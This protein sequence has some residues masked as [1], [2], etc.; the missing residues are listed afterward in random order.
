MNYLLLGHKRFTRDLDTRGCLWRT[1][2][3]GRDIRPKNTSCYNTPI[4]LGFP[5][6]F[7]PLLAPSVRYRS[8]ISETNLFEIELLN[9]AP[10]LSI[11][12]CWRAPSFVKTQDLP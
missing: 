9:V 7:F 5:P 4:P 3:K 12:A 8:L 2:A 10:L 11:Y 1:K 6:I